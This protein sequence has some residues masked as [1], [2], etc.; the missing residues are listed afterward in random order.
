MIDIKS[1]AFEISRTS[2]ALSM[3][4]LY[5]D[6]PAANKRGDSCLLNS[7]LSS[8]TSFVKFG[9]S[10]SGP[11]LQS[12]CQHLGK[13]HSSDRPSKLCFFRKFT[14]AMTNLRRAT[15]LLTN[16]EYLSPELSVH[17][18]RA[19]NI[20]DSLIDVTRWYRSETNLFGESFNCISWT[21]DLALH[22]KNDLTVRKIHFKYDV[23]RIFKSGKY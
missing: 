12:L 5:P 19:S 15:P 18:P 10:E 17:P 21:K 16:R 23:I 8:C 9:L 4:S 1:T 6:R 22:V 14:V 2:Y 7:S 3:T 20:L 13:L 11:F